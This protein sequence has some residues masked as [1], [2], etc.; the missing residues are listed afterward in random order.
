MAGTRDDVALSST[1]STP[2]KKPTPLRA[3]AQA[4]R[5]I[6]N[7]TRLTCCKAL[8]ALKAVAYR[9]SP[10]QRWRCASCANRLSRYSPTAAALSLRCSR[11][12]ASSTASAATHETGLPP[13]CERVLEVRLTYE[14]YFCE[15]YEIT[16]ERVYRREEERALGVRARNGARREHSRHRVAV[17]HRLAHRE[18]VRHQTAAIVLVGPEVR[19]TRTP[20][21]HLHLTT[22]SSAQFGQLRDTKLEVNV[23]SK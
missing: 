10:M 21:A 11:S 22:T 4:H 19:R 7:Q 13:N 9:T 8:A 5:H 6:E 18:N 1:S 14:R 16:C 23:T 15:R 3:I 17:A 2:R 20:K 12:M